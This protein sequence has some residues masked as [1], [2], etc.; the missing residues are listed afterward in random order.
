[1]PSLGG[2]PVP[3]VPSHCRL[4]AHASAA[5]RRA[6]EIP[7][8]QCYIRDHP[9]YVHQDRRPRRTDENPHSR[10]LPDRDTERRRYQCDARK[11]C[12][13]GPIDDAAETP[14]RTREPNSSA[15]QILEITN[16]H[17]AADLLRENGKQITS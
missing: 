2:E 6:E 5:K 10:I 1:M 8:A 12:C 9:Q 3:P 17:H 4:L 7:V 13:A 11:I 15:G 14:R 16:P